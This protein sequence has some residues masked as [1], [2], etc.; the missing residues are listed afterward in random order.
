MEKTILIIDGGYLRKISKKLHK[1]YTP[2]YIEKCA[3][4]ITEEENLL[5][6]LYYDCLPY[7][8]EVI[9]PISKNKKKFESVDWMEKLGKKEFFAIRKG[10]LKFRG[11]TLK[12][13]SQGKANLTD[14]DFEPNFEQKGVDMRIGLDIASYSH[15][16]IV[17]KIIIVTNDTDCVP[18]LKDAR[19]N[20]ISISLVE[21]N[22]VN[23]SYEL[24]L[25]VDKQIKIELP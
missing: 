14:D 6:I 21:L 13:E 23:L 2:E 5:R 8:G 25:H 10:K 17:D 7:E 3:Q 12:K 9:L 11:Y 20:G 24:L 16:R 22:S 1:K 15:N 19:R 18:A 4:K